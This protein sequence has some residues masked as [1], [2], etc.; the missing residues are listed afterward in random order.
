MSRPP[1]AAVRK[2][3]GA[4]QSRGATAALVPVTQK[5]DIEGLAVEAE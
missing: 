1:L 2:A 4:P 3:L 5:H